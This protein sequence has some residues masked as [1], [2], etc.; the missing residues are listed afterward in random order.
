SRIAEDLRQEFERLLRAVGDEDLVRFR[1]DA[2]E[3]HQRRE[4]FA[5]REH[6][7]GAGVAE[8]IFARLVSFLQCF[9]RF[10]ESVLDDARVRV[11]A[12]ERD[13]L[14]PFEDAEQRA[15]LRTGHAGGALRVTI[16]VR[17]GHLSILRGFLRVRESYAKP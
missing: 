16:S 9:E 6:P 8:R 1:L 15:D 11:T 13:D 3:R 10:P 5:E 7:T 2:L 4:L 17:V 14:G 12:R